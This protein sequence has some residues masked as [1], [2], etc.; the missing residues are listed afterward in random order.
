MAQSEGFKYIMV[1]AAED[2]DVVIMAGLASDEAIEGNSAPEGNGGNA[3]AMPAV[4][5]LDESAEPE[6]A[7]QPMPEPVRQP[8]SKAARPRDDYREATLDD[9]KPT[10]MPLAQRVVIIAAIVC[11]IG[12][13]IY[14]LAFMG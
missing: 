13:I 3:P 2:E 7:W 14:C 11:I 6:A 1:T 4:E 9:L 8:A 12:A 5:Q 10:P